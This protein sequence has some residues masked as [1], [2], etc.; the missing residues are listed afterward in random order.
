MSDA[1]QQLF[2]LKVAVESIAIS[3]NEAYIEDLDICTQ[4]EQFSTSQVCRAQITRKVDFTQ[5]RICFSQ[6]IATFFQLES[7]FLLNRRRRSKNNHH[8]WEDIYIF[9]E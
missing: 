8:A 9:G 6:K 3:N 5:N 7:N 1:T 4:F 2:A